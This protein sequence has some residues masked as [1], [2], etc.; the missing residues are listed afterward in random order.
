MSSFLSPRGN[1]ALKVNPSIL[2]GMTV[3][4]T[5]TVRGSSWY[6]AVFAIMLFSTLVFGGLAFTQPRS[7]RI[8]HYITAAITGVASIAYFTMASNLGWAP[9]GVEF[10]RSNPKVGGRT[11]SIF[12]AR[13]VD[14]V[15]TTPLLL[16]DLLLTAGV[17]WPT[18][19]STIIF[20]EVMIIT[21]LI[22][23]L[24]SS[25]YKW[26]YFVFGCFAFFGV[27][28]N[29]NTA[30]LHTKSLG[31]DVTKAFLYTGVWT[32]F[33]WFFYPIAWGLSEGGNVISPD[34]EAVFYGI[35]DILAKPV[36]GALLLFFH[37]GIDPARLGLHIRALESDAATHSSTHGAHHEKT[38]IPIA[39]NGAGVTGT[40]TT[41]TGPTTTSAV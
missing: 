4:E 18:I 41:T 7:K 20:D 39:H 27:I 11:R 9:I 28:W 14:W 13:Y 24:V 22:G 10:L 29:V 35:L 12:Y 17:P 31:A 1:D 25:N 8:F 2:N 33:L 36:F 26:G 15:I 37:R 16:L 32:L 6:W 3:D 19:M 34:G 30:R 40:T 21:G 5:I 23:A 38:A